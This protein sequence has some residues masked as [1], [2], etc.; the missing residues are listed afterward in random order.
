M[1]TVTALDRD[2]IVITKH[3]TLWGAERRKRKAFH[4]ERAR[5]ELASGFG[6]LS[7]ISAAIFGLSFGMIATL[8]FTHLSN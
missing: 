4:W 2:P 6:Y 7:A 5:I 3:L 1:W 8:L